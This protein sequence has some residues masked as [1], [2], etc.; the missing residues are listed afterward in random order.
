MPCSR[1]IRFELPIDDVGGQ[2]QRALAELRQLLRLDRRCPL[3]R[4][5]DDDDFVGAIDELL[6]HGLG[7]RLAEHAADEF[8][9]LGDVLEVDRVR[10]EMPAS[11]SSSTSS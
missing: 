8:L 7:L 11:S 1:K 10:T 2:Q 6:R 4:R 5:V 3:G 9:L